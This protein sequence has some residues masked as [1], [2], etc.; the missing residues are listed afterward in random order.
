MNAGKGMCVG[1]SAAEPLDKRGRFTDYVRSIQL[2]PIRRLHMVIEK[3]TFKEYCDAFIEEVKQK[4]CNRKND[5]N[6]DLVA[7]FG[8]HANTVSKRFKSYYGKSILELYKELVLP[9]KNEL[10]S[11]VVCSESWEEVCE[12]LQLNTHFRRGLMDKYYGVSSFAKAK[13]LCCLDIKD[14][15]FDPSICNNKALVIS[16]FFGDGHY[17]AVRGAFIITHG[18]KQQGYLTYKVGLFNK[19]FPTSKPVNRIR[20]YKHIQGHNYF[21]WYSGRLPSKLTSYLEETNPRDMVK[22]LTPLG[23]LLWFLDDGYFDLDFTKRSNNYISI[24]VHNTD[25]LI[26]LQEELLTYQ[27]NSTT[28]NNVLKIGSYQSAVNFYK[29]FMEHYKNDVPECMQYK[30]EMKI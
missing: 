8:I 27:I 28:C 26:A 10:T 23:I 14:V 29:N 1:Q 11:A 9:T 24:Y 16:Q 30:F 18:E 17:D 5:L 21:N 22:E 7:K 15:V 3:L 19:A 20:K 25:V 2:F 12:K 13:A 4:R 6:E